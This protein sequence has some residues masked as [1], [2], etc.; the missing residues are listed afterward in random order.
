MQEGQLDRHIARMRKIYRHRRDELITA[1]EGAFPGKVEILGR[2]TGLHIAGSFE[3]FVFDPP[4]VK[5]IQ[6]EGV[7]L[8]PVEDFAILKGHH[9]SRVAMGYSH[10]GI[11]EIRE[12]I[13]RIAHVLSICRPRMQS[14]MS[15][16]RA[17]E[18][19]SGG[20]VRGE[21]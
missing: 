3:G 6:R 12:G 10:L 8:H 9:A 13:A 15:R 1:L 4:L 14:A 21:R 18:V 20:G 5:S 17:E 11:P 16:I 7:I 19:V 2:A